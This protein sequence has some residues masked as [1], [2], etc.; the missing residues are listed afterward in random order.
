MDAWGAR[1]FAFHRYAGYLSA[2]LAALHLL[3]NWS[4]V[5]AYLR[6]RLKRMKARR[7]PTARSGGVSLPARLSRR[8]FF[9]VL[10]AAVG[11]YILGRSPTGAQR[12]APVLEGADVSVL[13]HRWSS[14]GRFW[15]FRAPRWGGRPARYKTY[16]NVERIQLPDPRAFRGLSF[17]ET[18]EQRRSHRNFRQ[19]PLSLE[20][21]SRLVHAAQGI[22]E[23][24]S[25][26]RAAPSAGA[27]YPI[28]VYV[29]AHRVTQLP[30]GIYHY[31]VREHSLNLLKQGDFRSA[32]MQAGLWQEFLADA[33]VCL[34]LS[35]I[36]QRTRWKYRERAYRYIWLEA[37]HIG[38]NIYLAA[39][40][41]GLGACAVGAFH[42]DQLNELLGIDGEEEAALYLL[43]VGK[44]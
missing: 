35:A 11:G 2:A 5:R 33:N 36:F 13:Y 30:S 4:R 17:E 8:E 28:E 41:M 40:S 27:L 10:F 25:E 26:F 12:L 29:A 43:A 19:E 37:G 22:T 39:T 1:Q 38:Q 20:E 44:I 14:P 3:F 32:L 6:W 9:Y 18:V 24:R 16:A 21:L 34:I 42:D 31:A 15:P 23:P 7:T